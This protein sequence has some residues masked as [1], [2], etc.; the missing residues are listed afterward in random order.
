M[1][2][3][4]LNSL[5]INAMAA[6]ESPNQFNKL[7]FFLEGKKFGLF[8]SRLQCHTAC[9]GVTYLFTKGFGGSLNF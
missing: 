1:N 9:I 8:D 4:N 7:N 5:Y 2:Q 3:Y 6:K